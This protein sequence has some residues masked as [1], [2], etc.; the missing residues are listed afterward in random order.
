MAR[1][2]TRGGRRPTIGRPT[3]PTPTPRTHYFLDNKAGYRR[4]YFPDRV[5]SLHIR[6]ESGALYELYITERFRT[7]DEICA[8]YIV[9]PSGEILEATITRGIRNAH[10]RLLSHG[11]DFFWELA[12]SEP[13][14]SPDDLI[15]LFELDPEFG[16]CILAARQTLFL[17]SE[18]YKLNF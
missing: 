8:L 5:V 10:L 7:A 3:E 4:E 15:T 18:Y 12:R 11:S 17:A 2:C 9:A 14:W 16:Q 13:R 1:T 6:H